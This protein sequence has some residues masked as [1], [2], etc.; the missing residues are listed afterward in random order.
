[1]STLHQ[2]KNR[3]RATIMN[4]GTTKTAKI[5]T[6]FNQLKQ[7][8]PCVAGIDIGS[9]VLAVCIGTTSGAQYVQ[10]FGT[11]TEDIQKMIAWFKE[12]SITSVAME[13]T[14]VYWIPVYDMLSQ[15]GIATILANPYKLKAA[16]G[17]KSDIMDC[18]W[19]QQLHSYGLLAGSFRPDNH[20]VTLRALVRQR[21]KLVM[22]AGN[23]LNRAHKTLVEMNIQLS[24]VLS[25]IS[26]ET[27]M[28]IIRAIIAGE[29]NPYVLAQN[30][31]SQCKQPE[32]QIAKALHGNFR[33]ELIFSLKQHIEIYDFLH[34]QVT[35][36]ETEIE[37]ILDSIPKLD[38]P[39]ASMDSKK[40]KRRKTAA[41]K[42]Q[43]SFDIIAELTKILGVNIA[44][45]PGIDANTAIKIISEIGTDIS[46]W[47]SAKQFASW[48][49]LCP[50]TEKSG[51][52][53]IN[54]KT[55][56]STNR[57]GQALRM[58]ASALHHANSSF[59]G[60]FRKVRSRVGAP[61]AITAT[62][63][64]IARTIYAMLKSKKGYQELGLEAFEQQHRERTVNG[65]N[66]KAAAM[67]YKLVP[68]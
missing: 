39:I 38:L 21:S 3:K 65:L 52:K 41:N 57:A 31:H 44:E 53:L 24:Q 42:R 16:P 45:I 68:A 5:K 63:H 58:A 25:D 30:R 15:A 67:G 27:G 28:K 29:H 54:S 40:E 46:R 59:G 20:I 32:E 10:E 55:A 56:P 60:F 49:G 48:L 6:K 2:I 43:Y 22:Q 62:A 19:I 51:G 66:R 1:M 11:Y 37:K 33:S 4:Q 26:G 34:T 8:N 9:K 64:K 47:S 35:E 36:C 14:G 13:A 23:C 61:K 50:G 12:F 7:V 17:R 18:E